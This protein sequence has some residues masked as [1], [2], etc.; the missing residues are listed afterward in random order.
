MKTCSIPGCENKCKT[1]GYCQTHYT[2]MLK[3]GDPLYTKTEM[4]G[5]SKIPEYRTW[6]GMKRRCYNRRGTGY[7]LYGGRGIAVC[8]RWLNSFEN[9]YED[10]GSKPF[11]KAEIDRI[12]NDKGYSPE[13]CRWATHA[14]NGQ[15]QRRTKLT[16]E[17]AIEIRKVYRLGNIS[18]R[19]LARKYSVCHST[20]KSVVNN[21]E[22]KETR[23]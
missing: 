15:N 2:R 10:M 12:D 6:A 23:K 18:H 3:Y 17:K 19:K 20:I 13:N 9:F 22:W 4:H 1:K 16:M 14:Q 11:P 5:L 8:D 21:R 7:H